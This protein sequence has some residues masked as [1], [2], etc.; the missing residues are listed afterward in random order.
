MKNN[1]I[2]LIFISISTFSCKV[3]K[4]SNEVFFQDISECKNI[5]TLRYGDKSFFDTCYV[6]KLE[7][8]YK[9]IL[10]SISQLE[11]CNDTLY[12]Y[13][14][15]TERIKVFNT[16]GHYL[17]DFA[18]KGNGHGEYLSI[19]S[20]FIDEDKHNLCIIDPLKQAIH[21]YT[22]SGKYLNSIKNKSH[23]LSK[24]KKASVVDSMNI[25]CSLATSWEDDNYQL[26]ILDPMTYSIK[27]ILSAYPFKSPLYESTSISKSPFAVHD[28][29]IHYLRFLSDTVYSYRKAERYLFKKGQDIRSSGNLK[30]LAKQLNYDYFRLITK[31]SKEGTYSTG[32]NN[33]YESNRF[34]LLEYSAGQF[35]DRGFLW[36]KHKSTGYNIENY[37]DYLPDFGSITFSK[38]DLFV[39][40]WN[41]DA[42]S[43]FKSSTNKS[44]KNSYPKEIWNIV[45]NHDFDN[46][47]PLL[48][49]FK[50]KYK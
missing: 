2:C 3:E 29:E 21:T 48:I 22:T 32:Y 16:S 31:I 15:Q 47:N 24:I 7:T 20:F 46:D 9:S 19:S 43:A 18:E 28:D 17:T 34:I 13:D 35:K 27:E 6:I 10:A 30:S 26:I 11:I 45:D 5:E 4:S 41:N 42:I 37:T 36:D 14:A 8:S 1:L 38:N 12:I 44:V 39:R 49:V 25:I 33:I 40:I 50:M 23:Y